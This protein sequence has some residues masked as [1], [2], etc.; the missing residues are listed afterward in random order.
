MKVVYLN[1]KDGENAV[2]L[3]IK[4][5]LDEY[6]KLC[7]CRYVEMLAR[8]IGRSRKYYTVVCDEEGLFVESPKI[9]AIDDFGSPQLVGNLV[10]CGD[11]DDEGE[12]TGLDESD[13]AHI[14]RHVRKMCTHKHADGYYMLTQISA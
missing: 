12:L 3:D 1:V 5:E 7:Q 4:D 9:S 13:I 10:I 8:K 11:A 2:V 6:Y 14:L